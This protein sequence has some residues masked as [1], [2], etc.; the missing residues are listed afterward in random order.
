LNPPR[1]IDDVREA[2]ETF[3]DLLS[4]LLDSFEAVFA[5]VY[6]RIDAI[7]ANEPTA[8]SVK[9]LLGRVPNNPQVW[10]HIFS[11]VQGCA[12]LRRF[13]NASIFNNPPSFGFW[14]QAQYLNRMAESCPE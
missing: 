14:P 6:T 13:V 5:D 1:S 11:Q 8:N 3:Q 7:A 4:M 12:W 10:A 2:W 9:Y